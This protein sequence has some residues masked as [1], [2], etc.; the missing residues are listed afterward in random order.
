[1][2]RLLDDASL[3]T[4]R[5]TLLAEIAEAEQLQKE[6]LARVRELMAQEDAT[7]GVF[8]AGEIHSAKQRAMMLRYQK[9]LRVARLNRM[10]YSSL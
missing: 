9:D 1:M 7:K 3:P 6:C 5:E 2:T 8:F 10:E 4:D